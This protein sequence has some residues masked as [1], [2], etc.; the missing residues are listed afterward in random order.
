MNMSENVLKSKDINSKKIKRKYKTKETEVAF[1]DAHIEEID[2]LYATGKC[3]LNFNSFIEKEQE[4]NTSYNK[5]TITFGNKNSFF[6]Q[7]V[8]EDYV[9]NLSSNASDKCLKVSSSNSSDRMGEVDE[10]LNQ[11]KDNIT[12]ET[13]LETTLAADSSKKKS[14]SSVLPDNSQSSYKDT[15]GNILIQLTSCIHFSDS[16]SPLHTNSLFNNENKCTPIIL[17][18][19]FECRVD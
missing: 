8:K 7:N 15:L 1:F 14:L 4:E 16:I 5:N 11:Q 3:N 9:D 2:P 17:T 13:L 19:Q 6:L 18:P 12:F 10:I